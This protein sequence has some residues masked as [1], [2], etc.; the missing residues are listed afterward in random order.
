MEEEPA[1]PPSGPWAR[2]R[3][4]VDRHRA[5]IARAVLLLFGADVL[6]DLSRSLPTETTLELE[7]GAAH[8]EAVS[9]DVVVLGSDGEVVRS[10]RRSHPSGAPRTLTE[11]LDLTPGRY[12]VRI[13]ARRADASRF[14]LEGAFE[15]PAEGTLHVT[16]HAVP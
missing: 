16:L 10:V 13:E 8:D 6:L 1:A 14:D 5:R 12:R 3:A 7:L 2:M 11:T 9:L 4:F 15:A